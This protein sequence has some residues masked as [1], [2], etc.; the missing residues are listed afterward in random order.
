MLQDGSTTTT[1]GLGSLARLSAIYRHVRMIPVSE[2]LQAVLGASHTWFPKGYIACNRVLINI[3]A[4]CYRSLPSD[5]FRL[6]GD[7]PKSAKASSK[8]PPKAEGLISAV[9][10]SQDILLLALLSKMASNFF[11]ADP[12]IYYSL[13]YGWHDAGFAY[14]APNIYVGGYHADVNANSPGGGSLIQYPAVQWQFYPVT[15]PPNGTYFLR[16]HLQQNGY[17]NSYNHSTGN[18]SAVSLSS[19]KL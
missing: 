2:E 7:T 10:R 8:Q 9:I 1:S 4:A 3:R 6:I 15:S 5:H 19:R 18:Q 11:I 16:S 17:F 12:N 13:T 14:L